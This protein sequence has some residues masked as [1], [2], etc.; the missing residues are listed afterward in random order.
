[1]PLSL[2]YVFTLHVEL[3]PPL[4]FGSTHTGDRRFIPIVGG[5]V[6]GPRLTGEILSGGGDWNSVRSDGV[7]HVL[8]KYAI[9]ADDGSLINIH[10]EGYGRATQADMRIVFGNDPASASLKKDG[11]EWYTKTFPRFEVADGPH[12]WLAKSCFLGDLLPPDRPNHVKVKVY[13]VI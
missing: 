1:M 11:A 3:A 12:V 2:E 6:E 9:M 10:N 4:D 5:R 13:E 7:V 8:A